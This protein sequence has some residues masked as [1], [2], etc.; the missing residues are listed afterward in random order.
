[1]THHAHDPHRRWLAIGGRKQNRTW[2]F[3]CTWHWR[4]WP[5]TWHWITADGLRWVQF[6]LLESSLLSHVSGR[7]AAV[8]NGVCRC[9]H[10]HNSR[11]ASHTAFRYLGHVSR[12][13]LRIKDVYLRI[14]DFLSWIILPQLKLDTII[15][16][17]S[18]FIS[19][20][21]LYVNFFKSN[22][23]QNWLR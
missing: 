6:S 17:F 12:I 15:Y 1:M 2:H 16:V 9:S 8:R 10:A 13:H 11:L 3:I 14:K 7:Q 19:I 4:A 21:V 5:L 20:K 22:L 18:I 23:K